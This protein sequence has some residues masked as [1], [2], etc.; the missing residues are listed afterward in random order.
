MAS[1]SW[2]DGEDKVKIL[3]VS[4]EIE[5]SDYDLRAAVSGLTQLHS[6]IIDLSGVTAAKGFFFEML[7]E[8]A[9]MTR[10]KVVTQVPEVSEICLQFAIVPFPTVRSAELSHRGDETV[11]QLLTSLRDVPSLTKD[12]QALVDYTTSKDADFE[13]VEKLLTSQPAIVSQIMRIANSAY[14]YRRQSVDTLPLAL[15]TIGMSYLTRIF[16]FNLFNGFVS[17]FKPQHDFFNGCILCAELSVFIA[18]AVGFDA[19]DISKVWIGGLL[20]DLGE[21]GMAFYFPEKYVASKHFAQTSPAPQ[22]MAE[23]IYFGINHQTLGQLM[24]VRWNFPQYLVEIIGNHHKNDL[25]KKNLV[26]PILCADA[27]ITSRKGGIGPSWDLMIKNIFKL[28]NCKIPWE[29]PQTEFETIISM[30]PLPLINGN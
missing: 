8:A 19:V 16:Q 27:Y 23:F 30:K 18:R 3:S 24:A 26:I 29:K 12:A 9:S 15:S 5:E 10:L 17:L 6:S 14:Y 2:H 20:H 1:F 7:Q 25:M 11:A 22:T 28:Y 4:G 13:G 21:M